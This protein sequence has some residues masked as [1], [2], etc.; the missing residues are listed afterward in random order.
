MS[1][2]HFLDFL[3]FSKILKNL[4]PIP[5]HKKPETRN[6]K[7]DTRHK[8]PDRLDPALIQTHFPLYSVFFSGSFFFQF[9]HSRIHHF[10]AL[11]ELNNVRNKCIIT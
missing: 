7:P 10:I 2:S 6:Q 1:V 8:T 5:S 11:N 4:K 9:G 3:D